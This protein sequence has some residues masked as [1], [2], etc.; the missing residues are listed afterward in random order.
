MYPRSMMADK[1]SKVTGM[2]LS[3][4]S[5]PSLQR[6]V[7][8]ASYKLIT[9]TAKPRSP[10]NLCCRLLA[11]RKWYYLGVEQV[12]RLATQMK[13]REMHLGA[14]SLYQA[15]AI[16]SEAGTQFLA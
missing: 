10:R 11:R 14:P 5:I 15:K 2:C 16:F 6:L 4:M 12:S 7:P 8:R 13:H 9:T 3:L 1:I